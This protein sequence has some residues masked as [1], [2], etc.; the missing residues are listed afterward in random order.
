[1]N[2]NYKGFDDTKVIIE[3]IEPIPKM[4]IYKVQP[5]YCYL[6]SYENYIINIDNKVIERVFEFE[7]ETILDEIPIKDLG[8]PEEIDDLLRKKDIWKKD[9]DKKRKLEDFSQPS[10]EL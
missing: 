4:N 3:R 10:E 8:S 7:A 2:V 1:M 6:P 5:Q 9:D